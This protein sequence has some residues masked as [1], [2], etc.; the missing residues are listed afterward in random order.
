MTPG[1]RVYLTSV[2]L[3]HC[4]K[5]IIHSC[6]GFQPLILAAGI[7]AQ[8]CS[9]VVLRTVQPWHKSGRGNPS[10]L[11]KNRYAKSVT[12]AARRERVGIA[13]SRHKT[14]K[15]NR[16]RSSKHP[17]STRTTSPN[18]TPHSYVHENMPNDTNYTVYGFQQAIAFTKQQTNVPIQLS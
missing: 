1:M 12:N 18:T 11:G 16:T 17:T 13:Y 14:Q 4:Q 3:A 15:L 10:V 2:V 9:N 6:M 8:D 7:R 5:R